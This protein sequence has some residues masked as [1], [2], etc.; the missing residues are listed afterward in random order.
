MDGCDSFSITDN[1]VLIMDKLQ[2]KEALHEVLQEHRSVDED[3]H[4]LH[5]DFLEGEIQR[6]E[7][8][9]AM[10]LKFQS[11]FIGGLALAI[12]GALSWVGHLVLEAFRSGGPHGS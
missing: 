7:E 8:R 1:G 9:H 6:R 12:L 11:S 3:Q 4:K 5:H 2:L 10:W